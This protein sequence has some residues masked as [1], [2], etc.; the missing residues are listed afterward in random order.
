MSSL[1]VWKFGLMGAVFSNFLIKPIQALFLFL[2]S[3]KFFTY[4]LNQWKLIYMPFV[5][6]VTGL[7]LYILS[8]DK[9]G[10]KPACIQFVIT[11]LLVYFTYK[12]ELFQLLV[13]LFSGKGRASV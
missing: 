13:P 1:L 2:E 12:K 10:I 7:L 8:P 5:V 11:A 3:R 4:H 6:I 9:T